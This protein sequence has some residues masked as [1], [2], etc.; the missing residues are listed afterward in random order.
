MFWLKETWY[1][2]KTCKFAFPQ[3]EIGSHQ[4]HTFWVVPG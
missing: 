1:Y 4:G 3:S 2:C